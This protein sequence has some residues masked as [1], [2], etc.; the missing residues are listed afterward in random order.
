[1]LF[2]KKCCQ[3]GEEANH[4]DTMGTMAGDLTWWYCYKHWKEKQDTMEYRK[5]ENQRI[6]ERNRVEAERR[7]KYEELER[8]IH[9]RELE[10]KAKELGI[11]FNGQV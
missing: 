6:N 9:Y 11:E 7:I 1:M 4:R 5:R 8:E 10:K 2:K 3:C